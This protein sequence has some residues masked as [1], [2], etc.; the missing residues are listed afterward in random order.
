MRS[1]L[2]RLNAGLVVSLVFLFALQWVLVSLSIRYLIEDYIAA[3]L[4]HDAENLLTALTLTP[5][6]EARLDYSRID[7]IFHRPFSGHYFDI[8]V[9]PSTSRE[10]FSL[11]SR[12]LWDEDLS[13]PPLLPGQSGLRHVA[14]PQGQA[15]VVHFSGFE[16][17]GHVV[18]IGVAE[19]LTPLDADVWRFQWRYAI[20]SSLILLVL[21]GLQSGIVRLSLKP[22]SQAREDI[23]RLERG[24]V[25]QLRDDV[26][27]EILPLV[28]ELNCLL[29]A[30]AQRLERSRH[31]LG[32]LAH[33]LKT[34]L[35]SLTQLANDPRLRGN[36]ALRGRLLEHTGSLRRIIERELKHARLAGG[37]APGQQVAL[38]QEVRHLIAALQGIYREKNLDIG[39][40]VPAG[41][42][43][44]GDREDL[45]ELLGNLLDNA[46]KWARYRVVLTVRQEA[47]LSLV[48]ED[49]GPGCPSELLD[50][51]TRR[52]VRIDESTAGHGL[53]LAIVRDVVTSY[54][55]EIRFGRSAA[56]GGFEARVHLPSP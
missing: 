14:G 5:E 2:A 21:I 28:R 56:L 13:V 23:A 52:G 47:G 27:A 30:L 33:A 41:A 44:P 1:L 29:E 19:D 20:A 51:L 55:G 17:Q 42:R 43:F 39:W 34:P 22:L 45:L 50:E 32:N 36:E 12:S 6:G 10:P 40:Y 35:T 38:E 4:R 49:D 18:A 11:H 8:T 54:G 24:E 37:A 25:R 9:N 26:P 7:P 31:A 16:K 53:G 15:L 3:R 48:V 46:C